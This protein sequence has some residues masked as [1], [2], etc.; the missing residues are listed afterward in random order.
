MAP[1]SELPRALNQVWALARAKKLARLQ[2]EILN[3]ATQLRE[4]V[5]PVVSLPQFQATVIQKGS[6]KELAQDRPLASPMAL[7]PAYS[8]VTKLAAR[9]CR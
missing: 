9:Q 5:S 6:K 2:E 4:A 3:Q 1:G 7:L 8:L